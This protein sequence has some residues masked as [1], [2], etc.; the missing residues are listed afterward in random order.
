[1][2]MCS[3]HATVETFYELKKFHPQPDAMQV[4][5]LEAGL[6]LAM[7]HVSKLADGA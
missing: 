7:T 1:M 6:V 4:A 3:P 2:A 5:A